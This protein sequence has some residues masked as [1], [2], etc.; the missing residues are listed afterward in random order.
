[1]LQKINLLA[2][3][4]YSGTCTNSNINS[5]FVHVQVVRQAFRPQTPKKVWGQRNYYR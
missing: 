3:C 1:M 5:V 2:T 4:S